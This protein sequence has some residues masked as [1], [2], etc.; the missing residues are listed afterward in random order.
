MFSVQCLVFSLQCSVFRVQ[1]SGTRVQGSGFKVQGSRFRV[2]SSGPGVRVQGRVTGYGF[3]TQSSGSPGFSV[4]DFGVL[5]YGGFIV[6]C[7]YGSGLR[8]RRVSGH[9]DI[10]VWEYKVLG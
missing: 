7:V 10:R 9:K 3:R 6:L 1:G 4:N 5:G 2:Q 8:F